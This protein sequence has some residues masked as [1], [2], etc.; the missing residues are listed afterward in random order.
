MKFTLARIPLS[1]QFGAAALLFAAALLS[2][3][4]T[5]STA[6]DRERRRASTRSDLAA[7]GGALAKSGADVLA[8]LPRWPDLPSPDEWSRTD[9]S[10]AERNRA[11]LQGFRGVE[12]GFFVRERR[13]FLGHARWFG[14]RPKLPY[15]ASKKDEAT[16]RRRLATASEPEAP[17]IVADASA[18]PP[19]S[20]E[21]EL[22]EIQADA[23]I[24]R[25]QV[26]FV[27]QESPP[28]AV[29][30][31]ASPVEV[32]GRIVGAAW[33]L[34]RMVDPIFLGRSLRGSNIAAGLALGGLALSTA[35]TASLARTV[36]RQRVERDRLQ[37]ELRRS[38]RLAALGKLLAG[39][40]HEV[41]NP[42]AGIRS[43]V[44]LWQRGI[45]PDPES[46]ED[47]LAEVDRLEGIVAR[48][49]QFSRAD[50][51]A[52]VAGDLNVVVAEV[53]RLARAQAEPLHVSVEVDLDARMPAVAMSPPAVI[54]VLRNLTTNALQALPEGG[55]LRLETRFDPERRVALARVIDDGPGVP[56]DVMTHLFEPFFTTKPG[57][58][59]LGL[60]IAR[61]IA[62][63]HRGELGVEKRVDGRSGAVFT[64][65]LP[66]DETP[67]ESVP[68]SDAHQHKEDDHDG[69]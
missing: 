40:A 25:N 56:H 57:G 69:T 32:D 12:G 66:V 39:V 30:I 47:L 3:W 45:G 44:Q 41:R 21:A 67:I 50:A 53:G 29:A 19:M 60:A 36:R 16:P 17:A 31:W 58:T 48:L 61:E 2:L 65:V 62:L 38:E 52:L 43:S 7:A 18:A 24:R 20:D 42:L 22:V 49:L 51:Q 34:T 26:L 23:A 64:L 14:P 8:E 6:V 33:T 55:S 11:I 5:W 68:S 28:G 63:A 13:Q 46:F 10:L 37:A 59:G 35:L 1:V 27:I 54:Q 15:P 9:Q 4:L